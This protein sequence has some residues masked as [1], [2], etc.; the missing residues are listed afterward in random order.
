VRKDQPLVVL[1]SPDLV[2]VQNDL[3]LVRPDV[4]KARVGLDTAKTV[5]ERARRLHEQEAIATQVL[6]Q[7]E[8]D[9]IRARDEYR[10]AQ[11]GLAAV[12]S[13]LSLFGKDPKEIAGLPSAGRQIQL[14]QVSTSLG[15]YEKQLL[16]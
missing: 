5:A 15:A 16:L 3:G 14:Q 1:E 8:A 9:L 4:A 2:T 10:R 11:V 12:E 13:R 6:Q 7:A